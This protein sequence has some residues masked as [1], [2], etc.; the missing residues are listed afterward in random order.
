[1]QCYCFRLYTYNPS[2]SLPVFF[3]FISCL[4]L[5]YFLFIYSALQ[6]SLN[7]TREYALVVR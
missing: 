4:F 1:M 2:C 3:L 5:V 6:K 7:L